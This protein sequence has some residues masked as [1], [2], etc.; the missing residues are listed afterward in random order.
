MM[1]VTSTMTK[2]R[3]SRT[4]STLRVLETKSWQ[5]VRRMTRWTRMTVT[6]QMTTRMMKAPQALIGSRFLMALIFLSASIS[7]S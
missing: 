1:I 2:K 4:I 7:P 5:L 6:C 3:M